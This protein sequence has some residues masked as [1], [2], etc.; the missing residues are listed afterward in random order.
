MLA[1]N[2]TR[3]S[4][5]LLGR[6]HGDTIANQWPGDTQNT[7]QVSIAGT[8]R[9]G[10]TF[11]LVLESYHLCPG[12]QI[13]GCFV[14]ELRRRS[15]SGVLE[16]IARRVPQEGTYFGFIP[17]AA[18][19]MPGWV[20]YHEI[21]HHTY[22]P[23]V[24]RLV[25][26]A[27]PDSPGPYRPYTTCQQRGDCP[28]VPGPIDPGPI[29]SPT[30]TLSL[31]APTGLTAGQVGTVQ[32][33]VLGLAG[34]AFGTPMSFRVISGANVGASGMCDVTPCITDLAGR[35]RF[36]YRS[37][38]DG[39]DQI[40]AWIDLDH[41]GQPSSGEPQATVPVDWR[42]A[43]GNTPY[44]AMGDSFS[45]G[46]GLGPGKPYIAGTDDDFA[47]SPNHC[48]RNN[49]AYAPLL[50]RA[51]GLKGLSSMTFVACSGAETDD[52]VNSNVNNGGEPAQFTRAGNR[53]ETVTLTIG[54]ND[55]GFVDILTRCVV[56]PLAHG[57]AGC[58]K[59]PSLRQTTR[60]RLGV[61]EG[62]RTDTTRGGRKIRTPDG[63]KI[64]SLDDL[65][66][67]LHSRAAHAHVFLSGY[68][69]LFGNPTST[70]GSCTVSIGGYRIA[71]SD[72]EWINLQTDLLNGVMK[73]V[74]SAAR[75]PRFAVTYVDPT[76]TFAGHGNC[77]QDDAWVHKLI[78][79]K[80]VLV[81]WSVIPGKPES[82]HPTAKGQRL[83]YYQAFRDAAI[84]R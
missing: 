64:W 53:T 81:D 51:K 41:D 57:A 30:P 48:H 20:V 62:T 82:F 33:Q 65:L 78:L 13:Q 55:L 61:F 15:P 80:T 21:E 44:V 73:R 23:R 35:A 75:S 17:A 24:D 69:H 50:S 39:T 8:D 4:G 56:G 3:D 38:R 16:T 46:E 2:D 43:P 68:P 76:E 19:L 63:R 9:A 27:V 14:I 36:R 59:D 66:V 10:S 52:L 12:G 58:T 45:A 22:E 70:D 60:E 18:Q 72:I 49:S 6:A 1:I 5:Y 67:K 26:F 71:N 11:F 31:T 7:L 54:G 37:K 34:P 25:G 74:A 77:D 28:I 29:L 79:N 47:P 84:G 40:L 42:P 32:S 83:G